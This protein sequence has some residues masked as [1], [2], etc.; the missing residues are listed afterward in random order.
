MVEEPQP[1]NLTGVQES[2]KPLKSEAQAVVDKVIDK[3]VIVTITD[4]R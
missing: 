4:D 2:P 1:I 3:M